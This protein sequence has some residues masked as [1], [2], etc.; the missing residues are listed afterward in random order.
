MNN[1][2]NDERWTREVDKVRFITSVLRPMVH[3]LCTRSNK[4]M[5]LTS[6][7]RME[8]SDHLDKHAQSWQES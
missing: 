4:L 7:F 3:F 1:P 2:A 5:K 8:R 6:T